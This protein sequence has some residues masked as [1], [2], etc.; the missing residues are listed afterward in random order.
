MLFLVYQTIKKLNTY[1]AQ[2]M[3]SY[4]EVDCAVQLIESCCHFLPTC[5]KSVKS[6]TLPLLKY[7][8]TL[9]SLMDIHTAGRPKSACVFLLHICLKHPVNES[10]RQ[11]LY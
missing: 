6:I 3:T 10:L 4:T 9:Q 8:K 2:R 11:H 7:K 1:C 5:Q